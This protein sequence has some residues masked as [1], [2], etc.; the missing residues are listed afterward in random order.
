MQT[1]ARPADEDIRIDTLQSLKILDTPAEERFDRLTRIASRLFDVPVALVSL[2]DENRV[3][4][5]S[6]QGTEESGAVQFVITTRTHCSLQNAHT[7]RCHQ[8]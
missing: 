1:P 8:L 2:V 6:A 4:Y 7:E 5:K 3:W